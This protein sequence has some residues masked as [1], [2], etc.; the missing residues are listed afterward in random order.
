MGRHGHTTAG[1]RRRNTF[2]LVFVLGVVVWTLPRGLHSRDPRVQR[3]SKGGA[4]GSP[5]SSSNAAPDSPASLAGSVRARGGE[6]LATARVCATDLAL[7]SVGAPAPA[8]VQTDDKGRYVIPGL[9]PGGYALTAE[10]EGFMPGAAA[11]GKPIVL[12]SGESKSGIDIV[13]EEGGAKLAGLVLDATGGPVPGA[14]IRAI[15]VT[16]PSKALAVTANREGRFVVWVMPGPV[17]II[18]EAVGYASARTLRTAPSSDVVLTLTPGSNISGD[19]V[20]TSDETAVANV[21]VRAVAA[22]GWAS[23]MHPSG[24]TNADG[25]FTVHGLEPGEYSLVAEGVGWRGSSASPVQIGLAESLDHVRIHVSSAVFVSGKVVLRSSGEPCQQGSVTLGPTSPWMTS[26]FD[27]PSGAGET[28]VSNVPTMVAPIEPNGEVHFRAVTAGAYHVIVQCPDKVFSEGPKTLEVRGA[29]VQDVTWKV[30]DGLGMVVHVVDEAERPVPGAP[31]VLVWPASAPGAPTAMMPLWVDSAG[32]C[33]VPG[34]LYPGT[35]TVQPERGYDGTPVPIELRAGAGRTDAT[36]RLGGTGSILVAVQSREG[37]AVDDVTVSA[38]LVPGSAG[39]DAAAP[40]PR[41]VAAVA[42]GDGHFRIAPLPEG[43]YRIEASDGVNPPATASTAVGTGAARQTTIVL[44]RDLGIRGRIVDGANQPAP[45]TWVSATCRQDGTAAEDGA[46]PPTPTRRVVSDSQG[47]FAV[48]NLQRGTL[49]LVRA[50]RPHGSLALKEDVRPG[51]DVTL[52][53]PDL[54]ALR[55]SALL[56]E[57]LGV[58]S[59]L[60]HR[61]RAYVGSFAHRGAGVRARALGAGEGRARPAPDHRLGRPWCCGASPSRSRARSDGR[62]PAAVSRA[63][64]R[65]RNPVVQDQRQT[66]REVHES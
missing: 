41:T 45:D 22:G 27:P 17:T 18:G 38:T 28:T 55:G 49:C 39:P 7:E 32:R 53:L 62:R 25:A 4:S 10:A 31:F 9:F 3:P 34:V 15:R 43:S 40:P 56:P 11:E 6:A 58:E 35:Y 64:G 20:T 33:E 29:D 24:T 52:A 46:R 2:V 47:R 13:L 57:G 51:D 63:A 60:H 26:P 65:R 50:E 5:V 44:D 61:A 59:L 30:D 54:G 12:G 16:P 37:E 23:P 42:L 14:T 21:E 19:V 1:T 66:N 8:C 36:L 48:A